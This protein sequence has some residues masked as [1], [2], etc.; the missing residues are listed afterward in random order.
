[1]LPFSTL[2]FT[3]VPAA[4]LGVSALW[5]ALRARTNGSPLLAGAAGAVSA[6][7]VLFEYPAG[8]LCLALGLFLVAT[9]RPRI[10]TAIAF[11]GGMVAGLVPL[12]LYNWWAFGSITHLSYQNV[13]APKDW[14]EDVPGTP[15]RQAP[16]VSGPRT[17]A[18]P[19]SFCSPNGACS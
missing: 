13:V 7:A 4:A 16:S 5:L 2:Y 9:A 15:C 14:L 11:A 6:L 8:L 3:H 17:W 19:R 10:L 12:A 18:P 1:M